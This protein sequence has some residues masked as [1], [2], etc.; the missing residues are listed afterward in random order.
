MANISLP[1]YFW[2]IFCNEDYEIPSQCHESPLERNLL[3][4]SALAMRHGMTSCIPE[5]YLDLFTSQNLQTLLNQGGTLNVEILRYSTSYS[6]PLTETEE[7]VDV[8]WLALSDLSKLSLLKFLQVLW[9]A[10][11]D[12]QDPLPDGLPP[13]PLSL[14][15][16]T[17]FPSS[18]ELYQWKGSSLP[19]GPIRIGLSPEICENESSLPSSVGISIPHYGVILLPRYTTSYLTMSHN[20]RIF[21]DTL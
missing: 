7:V 2:K 11:E 8:F 9:S 13:P 12:D 4:C 10:T 21:I 3:E 14:P 16:L 1:D 17:S 20:L 15:P 5:V 6:L 19:L 18:S